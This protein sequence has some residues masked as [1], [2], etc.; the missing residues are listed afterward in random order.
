MADS[1]DPQKRW[2]AGYCKTLDELRLA[3]DRRGPQTS[4]SKLYL[5]RQADAGKRPLVIYLAHS[6]FSAILPRKGYD[7]SILPK[8]HS[9]VILPIL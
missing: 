4:G 2:A 6:H 5:G 7:V 3:F 1:E 9:A 8:P